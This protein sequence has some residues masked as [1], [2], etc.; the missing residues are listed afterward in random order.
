MFGRRRFDERTSGALAEKSE[1]PR[2][3][4]RLIMTRGQ[5]SAPATPSDPRPARERFD[6]VAFI[7]A[8]L[9]L[10][11]IPS[12]PEISIHAARPASGL[13][14]LSRQGGAAHPPYWAY[15]WAGGAAL[16]RYFLDRP[17]IVSGRSVLDLGAGCGL[18]AIAAAKAGAKTVVAADTDANAIAALRLNAAA[19]GA[20]I[21]PLVGDVTQRAPPS[22]DL[23]AVG[24][25]FYEPGLA[26]RA[27]AFL[28]RCR[29]AGVEILIGDI[30]RAYLPRPRLRLLAEYPVKD[31][32]DGDNAALKPAG[33]FA[34]EA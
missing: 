32:G 7:E 33:V 34:F 4:Y 27:T 13:W 19:N 29:A 31:F 2:A 30:G 16:A 22:V 24:D 28:D 1:I 5:P 10:A 6:L 26:K 12:L 23:I 17:E 8:N 18:V 21:E 14:R 11:P 3:C 15:P 20:R 25:L 9:P